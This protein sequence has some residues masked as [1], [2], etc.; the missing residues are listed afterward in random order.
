[1]VA[2]SAVYGC[3][4][5]LGIKWSLNP[6]GN[7]LPLPSRLEYTGT[8]INRADNGKLAVGKTSVSFT[9]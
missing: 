4:P 8:G 1:M 3:A 5:C 6:Y 9:S 7:W 2:N